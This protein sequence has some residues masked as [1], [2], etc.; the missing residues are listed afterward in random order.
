MSTGTC[1]HLGG[2]AGDEVVHGLLGGQAGHGGQHTEGV[3]A[4]QDEVL[5]VAAHA[6]NLG[7]VDVVDGVAG[8]GVLCD[9]AA[10][11]RRGCQQARGQP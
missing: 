2:V 9:G 1:A 11:A 6:G 5:G 8:P 10:R 4:Q 7:V 3:A